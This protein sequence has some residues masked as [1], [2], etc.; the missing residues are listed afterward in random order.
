MTALPHGGN[1]SLWS[2]RPE[3]HSPVGRV[4]PGSRG[5]LRRSASRYRIALRSHVGAGRWLNSCSLIWSRES[6]MGASRG[7]SARTQGPKPYLPISSYLSPCS[8]TRCALG[9]PGKVRRG[10]HVGKRRALSSHREERPTSES[11]SFESSFENL[12]SRF[13]CR[14]V[15]RCLGSAAARSDGETLPAMKNLRKATVENSGAFAGVL[16]RNCGEIESAENTP[17]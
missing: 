6:R 9:I 2:R 1:S 8:A 16:W 5:R 15:Y 10:P 12:L 7:V 14:S 13:M 4:G 3:P 17:P 11:S